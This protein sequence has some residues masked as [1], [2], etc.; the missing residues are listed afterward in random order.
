MTGFGI[1]KESILLSLANNAP[2]LPLFDRFRYLFVRMAG[3]KIEQH[4]GIRAPFEIRSLGSACNISIGKG[5][6]INAGACFG[7]P[8]A[9]IS[10][11]RQ[12]LVGPRVIF[13]TVNRE[14]DILENGWRK[15]VS[16]KIVVEDRAWIGAGSIILPG[17]TI[18]KEAVVAAGA[19]VNRDV[20]AGVMVGGVPARAIGNCIEK[21]E[22]NG[23][24]P[25][26]LRLPHE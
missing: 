16:R 18:G 22:R 20:P 21:A 15:V 8:D 7:C 3:V 13:E 5:T 4:A 9:T 17:V 2:R 19:V 23:A 12:V 1:A 6:F 24:V 14:R 26:M 25:K 10:L 11:G